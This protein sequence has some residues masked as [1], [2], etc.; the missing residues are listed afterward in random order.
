M[1]PPDAS[2]RRGPQLIRFVSYS[3]TED[4]K[5]Q[6]DSIRKFRAN[7]VK[8]INSKETMQKKY[9]FLFRFETHKSYTKGTRVF[10]SR[11]FDEFERMRV[12][13]QHS[14]T[15]QNTRVRLPKFT[16]EVARLLCSKW[17]TSLQK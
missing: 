5:L 4:K 8:N 3:V 9:F 11:Y 10:I 1:L 16:C 7:I 17:Q 6:L 14:S 13:Y 2:T 12:V 15:C